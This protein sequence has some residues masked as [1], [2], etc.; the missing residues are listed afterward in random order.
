MSIAQTLLSAGRVLQ[1]DTMAIGDAEL[2]LA[3][4]IGK[5]IEFI[6]SHPEYN[7]RQDQKLRFNQLL[8]KRIAGHSIAVLVGYK[9]FYNLKFTVTEATLI[10]RPDSELLVDKALEY[11][12]ERQKAK[13]IDVGTGCGNLIIATAKNIQQSTRCTYFAVDISPEALRIARENAKQHEV[14]IHFLHSNIF[15]NIG[16]R[17]FNVIIAN[18]PYLNVEQ[19]HEPSIHREPI[20]ALWGGSH[21]TDLYAELFKQLPHFLARTYLVL[22]EIDPQQKNELIRLA[23]E[24]LPSSYATVYKDLSGNDRVLS[25]TN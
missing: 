12:S 20:G 1:K 23:S 24:A 21:G 15:S 10:P 5:D 9:F 8:T 14:K 25:I 17:K 3:H 6:H 4:C 16:R 7:I 22:I 2:L 13:I 11:L 18:L 19:L